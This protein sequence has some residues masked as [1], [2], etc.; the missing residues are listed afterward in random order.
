MKKVQINSTEKVYNS[1]KKLFKTGKPLTNLQI[2]KVAKLCVEYT[3]I[4]VLKLVKKGL[5][6]RD[7]KGHIVNVK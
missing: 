3:R 4:N 5:I 7:S 2:S 1:A 6:K